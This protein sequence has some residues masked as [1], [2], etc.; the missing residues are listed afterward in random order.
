MFLINIHKPNKTFLK[1]IFKTQFPFSAQEICA[2]PMDDKTDT[3]QG[4][5]DVIVSLCSKVNTGMQ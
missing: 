1:V 5:K 2:A 4:T 3:T